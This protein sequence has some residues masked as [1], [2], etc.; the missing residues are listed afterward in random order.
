[1]ESIS[2]PPATLIT[3]QIVAQVAIELANQLHTPK[4][5]IDKFGITVK[6]FKEIKN[7]PAFRT[8]Y[9]DAKAVWNGTGN[10]TERVRAKGNLLVEDLLIDLYTRA[11]DPN[12]SDEAMV[13]IVKQ[14]VE[15]SNLMPSK[16]AEQ[17]TG[18]RFSVIMNFTNPAGEKVEKTISGDAHADETS[19]DPDVIT[20]E[21][22]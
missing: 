18:A 4:E 21:T 10:S 16:Q 15:L 1:M 3:E 5:I 14:I 8:I 2:S 19:T 12:T 13:K 11:K 7:K 6:Q 20:V 22:D 17:A 9:S